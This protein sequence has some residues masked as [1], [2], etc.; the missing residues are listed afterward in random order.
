MTP[1]GPRQFWEKVFRFK[2]MQNLPLS[3]FH[4]AVW[5]ES[6]PGADL[7]TFQKVI[8]SVI[9]GLFGALQDYKRLPR[10]AIEHQKPLKTIGG[11][12]KTENR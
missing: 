4:V 5:P 6:L 12:A 7:S 3:I 9:W 8:F 11:V 1:K 2:I 10:L